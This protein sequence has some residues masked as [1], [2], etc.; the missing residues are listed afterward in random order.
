MKKLVVMSLLVSAALLPLSGANAE[1]RTQPNK[2]YIPWTWDDATAEPRIG[3]GQERD[4]G[5]TADSS[6]IGW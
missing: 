5:N 6:D 4:A 1:V 2:D 3:E